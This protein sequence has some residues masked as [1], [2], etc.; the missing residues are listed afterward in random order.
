[1]WKFCYSDLFTKR[2]K[3]AGLLRT[4][5]RGRNRAKSSSACGEVRHRSFSLKRSPVSLRY[6]RAQLARPSLPPVFAPAHLT[7]NERDIT[8]P[9][10]RTA[11]PSARSS[12]T[13][14]AC[15]GARPPV[16]AHID[17]PGQDPLRGPES[18]SALSPTLAHSHYRLN[19]NPTC[20]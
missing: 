17:P 3:F 9:V 2:P 5:E 8:A 7:L 15:T 16:A 13:G 20:I 4:E 14:I 19:T 10:S 6:G 11:M 1:V 12:A 18:A